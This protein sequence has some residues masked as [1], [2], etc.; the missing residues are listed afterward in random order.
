MLLEQKAIE[1][2][3]PGEISPTTNQ[4][5]DNDWQI[6]LPLK[7]NNSNI[8]ASS[9][10]NNSDDDVF[11]ND[12]TPP[13]DSITTV[14]SGN[15]PQIQTVAQINTARPGEPPPVPKVLT[16]E[17][18]PAA[19]ITESNGNQP[20]PPPY[21]VAITRHMDNKDS[22]ITTTASTTKN[23]LPTVSSSDRNNQQQQQD[24]DSEN[25]RGGYIPAARARLASLKSLG[26][27]KLNA[28]KMRLSDKRQKIEECKYIYFYVYS[29]NITSIWNLSRP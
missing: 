20:P 19:V 26:S 15:P 12:E 14:A 4:T 5:K 1:Y 3:Y 6:V 29:E 21:S 27:K 18:T 28:I 16:T 11:V 9:E 13:K 8:E 2:I 10:R 22:S 23:V 25:V 24:N 7:S 17:I